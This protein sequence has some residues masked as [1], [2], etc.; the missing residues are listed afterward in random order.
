MTRRRHRTLT[1]AEKDALLDRQAALM[2]TLMARIAALEAALAKPRK[3]SRNSH[4]PPSQDPG[5]GGSGGKDKAAAK[6]PRPSRPG[7][8]RRP[9]PAGRDDRAARG[10][11]LLRGG[12]VGA[13][14]VLPAAL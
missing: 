5:V 11:L 10:S 12:R 1:D 8:S 9:S 14:A 3:T 7:V 6:K 4:T 13:Q 2:D